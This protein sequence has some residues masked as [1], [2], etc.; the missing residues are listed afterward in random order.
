MSAFLLRQ[1]HRLSHPRFPQGWQ[2][3]LNEACWAK[4][5]AGDDGKSYRLMVVAD[6]VEQ[7]WRWS[8]PGYEGT[9]QFLPKAM[10]DAEKYFSGNG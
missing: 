7:C 9:S 5:Y 10:H 8:A 1:I 6:L 4:R 3:H 2:L